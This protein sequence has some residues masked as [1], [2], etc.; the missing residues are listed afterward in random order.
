MGFGI[1][2]RYES[3]ED[4]GGQGDKALRSKTNYF[5]PKGERSHDAEGEEREGTEKS[6]HPGR[7]GKKKE[8]KAKME[9]NGDSK[10]QIKTSPH[11]KT[12]GM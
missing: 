2:R 8:D 6:V 1:R 5:T 7:N 10:T 9:D 11:L 4:G 12:T 3:L